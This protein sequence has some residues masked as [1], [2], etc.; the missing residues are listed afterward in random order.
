MYKLVSLSSRNLYFKEGR[1]DIES[2]TLKYNECRG[3]IRCCELIFAG[4]MIN[5]Y[6]H[7]I[8]INYCPAPGMIITLIHINKCPFDA[9]PLQRLFHFKSP[10]TVYESIYFPTYLNSTRCYMLF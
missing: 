1:Q 3:H 9:L 6:I 4:N 5:I 7:K 8:R 10:L 2:R